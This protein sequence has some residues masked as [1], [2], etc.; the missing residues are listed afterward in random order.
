[1][2]RMLV[3]MKAKFRVEGDRRLYMAKLGTEPMDGTSA[4]VT[5]CCA[6]KNA[7]QGV[8]HHWFHECPGFD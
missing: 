6:C 2:A 8:K 7:G 5:A 1:M 4:P 3:A